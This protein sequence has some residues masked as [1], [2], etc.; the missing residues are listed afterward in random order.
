MLQGETQASDWCPP[1]F[2]WAYNEVLSPKMT[3]NG[4][5]PKR[6]RFSGLFCL[7][8]IDD[9]RDKVFSNRLCPYNSIRAKTAALLPLRKVRQNWPLLEQVGSCK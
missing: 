5:C 2:P 9:L 1:N 4:K 6:S 8:T 7:L 3:K